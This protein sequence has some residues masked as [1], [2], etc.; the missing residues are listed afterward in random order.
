[1]AVIAGRMPAMGIR[2]IRFVAGRMDNAGI[3]VDRDGAVTVRVV[4]VLD[5]VPAR[6]ARMRSEDRNQP[7]EY[8]ADQRQK[9]DCLDH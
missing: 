9:D 8:R 6:I 7:G 4:M 1:M 3:L 5:G 2:R